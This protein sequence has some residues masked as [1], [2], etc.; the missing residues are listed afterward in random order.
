MNTGES[1]LKFDDENEQIELK[2]KHW[3]IER[4]Y[5]FYC[6]YIK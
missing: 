4:G 6:C 3:R 5:S 2:K 1:I